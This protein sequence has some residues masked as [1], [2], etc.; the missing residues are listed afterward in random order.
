MKC[1][2]AFSLM[3]FFYSGHSREVLPAVIYPGEVTAGA[4]LS[5]DTV[6]HGTGFLI[7]TVNNI[8]DDLPRKHLVNG[9]SGL[10]ASKLIDPDSRLVLISDQF[11]FTEGPAAD[12]RGNIFFTDQPN[13][14]IWKYDVDGNLSV[15]M[16]RSGRSNGLYFDKAGNLVACA[17]EKDELWSISPDKQVT[18]L[19]KDY[20]GTRFNGP[21]DLWI[22]RNGD[23]YFTDPYYQ[24]NYWDR[25]KPDMK[26]ENL[27]RLS[28]TTRTVT[29]VDSN[30]V[31][32]NGIIGTKDG[33]TLFISDINANKIY[34][35]RITKNGNLTNRRLFAE[36]TSD[37]LTLDE[38]GN[39]YTTGKGVSVYNKRAEKIAHI[40]IP[41][42]WVGNITFG[43]KDGKTLFIAASDAVYY[44]NMRV[45]GQ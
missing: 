28:A 23:I 14:N 17:D 11:K 27:Y 29:V 6:K 35:Y 4:D 41:G 36:E 40:D 18:I 42:R 5:H 21:N 43:G 7:F 15:F 8:K 44:L 9:D 1:F 30:L 24:R 20:E 22:S 10:V 39:L 32:P 25:T 34:R 12:S 13:D 45:K 2:F 19:L 38:K 16:D 26:K 31:R 3:L 33:K 37:G